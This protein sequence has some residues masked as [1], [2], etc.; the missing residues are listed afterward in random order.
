M[1]SIKD[2]VPKNEQ[3]KTQKQPTKEQLEKT[4]AD[5]GDLVSLFLSRYAQLSEDELIEEMLKLIKQKKQEGTYDPEKL[6]ELALKVSP[7]LNSS[8][9]QKMEEL[10]KLL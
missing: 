7:F 6:K 2:F 5:Y 3:N 8:Q 9:Q 4:Q 10:L 1:S